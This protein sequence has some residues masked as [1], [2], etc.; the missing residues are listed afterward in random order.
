M[1]IDAGMDTG[2][3]LLQREIEIGRERDSARACRAIIRT[4]RTSDGGNAARIGGGNDCFESTEPRGRH[5]RSDVEERRRP[6]RLEPVGTGNLQPH[7]RFAP[8]PG[9]YTTFRGQ[10]CQV[11]GE[12]VSKEGGT[13]FPPE[14]APGTLFGGKNELL[15]CCGDTT[16]LLLRLVQLEGR[17]A[18]KAADFANGRA[19]ER[20][21]NAL[22]T[23][24]LRATERS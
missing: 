17:K 5:L 1:R 10:S 22:A 13:S 20:A 2:E 16:V 18:V 8:W 12:R 15:V 19:I 21:V 24:D 6:H 7:A 14:A 4:W 11:W 9:A 23:P 3:V